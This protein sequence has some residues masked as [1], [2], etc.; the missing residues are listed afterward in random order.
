MGARRWLS[1]SVLSVAVGCSGSSDDGGAA[2][3]GAAD[4]DLDPGDAREEV[5][6][7]KPSDVDAMRPAG[8]SDSGPG[9]D[10]TTGARDASTALCGDTG[11][12]W[13]DGNS[14]MCK[15]CG[16]DSTCQAAKYT[17]NRDG[18][19]TSSCCGLVWQ[20]VVSRDGP[21]NLEQGAAYCA[22]LALAGGG[23]RLPTIAELSSLVVLG[24]TPGSPAIDRTAF[25]NTPV[26]GPYWSCSRFRGGE[27]NAWNL[28]FY[29]GTAS[30]NLVTGV[31]HIRCVR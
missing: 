29:D 24:Q 26:T 9:T 23:W 14:N 31:R 4:G 11:C 22:E 20:Q 21:Y 19:V 2:D 16:N 7:S 8:G 5:D 18:T 15:V 6:A 12:E 27:R 28:F 13:T 30:G 3:G 25:P 17:D 10:G 1:I